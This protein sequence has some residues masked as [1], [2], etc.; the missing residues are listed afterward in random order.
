MTD[1]LDTLGRQLVDA[2][3]EHARRRASRAERRRRAMP[4]RLVT[5][6]VLLVLLTAA[7]ALAAEVLVTGS[8][9]PAPRGQSAATG[10]GIPA[11]GGSR[12]LALR[13]PDPAGGPP[14]GMRIVHTT[15]GLICVQVARVYQGQLGLLGTDGAFHDDGQFHPLPPD[16]IDAPPNLAVTAG[17]EN[18]VEPG[19]AFSNFTSGLPQ[20]GKLLIPRTGIAQ[21]TARASELR[22]ISFGLLGPHAR[23][24]TYRAHRRTITR[25]VEQPLGAYLIVEQGTQPGTTV[26]Q[27]A[28]S[29]GS[30]SFA[31]GAPI[32]GPTGAVT[33]ITYRLGTKFCQDTNSPK[34]P[35]ACPAGHL[36]GP[37]PPTPVSGRKLHHPVRVT[38]SRLAGRPSSAIVSFVAPYRVSNALTGYSVAIPTPC[39]KGTVID[40]IDR[41]VAAGQLVRTTVPDLFVNACGP[42][43]RV[44]ILFGPPDT[45]P[46][47]VRTIV[48]GQATIKTKTRKGS[49]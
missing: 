32:P 18:C 42:Q 38:L 34:A 33:A 3:D 10:V 28:T 2:A 44:Q 39:H 48:I 1:F 45:A 6:V 36:P 15:R 11:R 27:G 21:F 14:W 16:V 4:V 12:L 17:A 26:P 13:T 31:A 37:L 46:P 22:W 24:V 49:S 25:P 29:G 43:V 30:S 23:S 41:N 35:N 20:S 5:A 9:V 47:R 7:V 40:F 8:P 19:A